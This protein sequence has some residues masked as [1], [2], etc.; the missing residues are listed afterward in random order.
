LSN[1]NS[2]DH[3]ITGGLE[4]ALIKDIFGVTGE[5]GETYVVRQLQLFPVATFYDTKA[6][7]AANLM[8]FGNPRRYAGWIPSNV[9]ATVMVIFI[10]GGS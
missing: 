10:D 5:Q 9:G 6:L 3:D 4:V 7:I 1:S 2:F 8:M